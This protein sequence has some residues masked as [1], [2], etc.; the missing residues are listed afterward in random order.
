MAE[1]RSVRGVVQHALNQTPSAKLGGV[2]PITG[3]TQLPT[4]NALNVFTTDNEIVEVDQATLKTWRDTEVAQLAVARDQL[5]RTISTVAATRRDKERS[6]KNKAQL[7]K[8]L[9]LAV[10]DYVL[11]GRVHQTFAPKLQ[12]QWMG[13]RRIV[14]AVSDWVFVTEDL[15]CVTRTTQHASRLKMFAASDLMVTQNLIDHISYVEGG[16]LVEALVDCKFDRA[17]K[18]WFVLVKWVGIDELE[19]SW[20]P[21]IV[22]LE[23]VPKL[24]HKF[25]KDNSV[26]NSHARQ[27]AKACTEILTAEAGGTQPTATNKRRNRKKTNAP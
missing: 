23:D 15:R 11:V 13:P 10:G 1:W 22:M 25:L 20:E 5:H 12:V 14:E 26:S 18:Q 8:E 2:A 16:Y 4:G 7:R 6:R 3:M 24:V 19:N 9:R 21:L 17:T 27:M